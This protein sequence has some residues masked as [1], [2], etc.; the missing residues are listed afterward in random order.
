MSPAAIF[1]CSSALLLGIVVVWLC[2]PVIKAVG[3]FAQT[4]AQIY[5]QAYI[6]ASCLIL[7]AMGTTF[8]ETWQP[9]TKAQAADFAFWDWLI[10]IEAPLLSGLA[11]LSAFLDQSMQR[12]KEV[13]VAQDSKIADGS[14]T[15][16]QPPNQ[17]PPTPP[18]A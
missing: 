7:I 3:N 2:R 17:P 14:I 12:A 18:T 10:K 5:A 15:Q 1:L 4:H 8:K 9:I 11:V 13:K 6:K 16:F